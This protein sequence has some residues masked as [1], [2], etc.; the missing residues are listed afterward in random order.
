LIIQG[1]VCVVCE[2]GVKGYDGRFR[3]HLL[4]NESNYELQLSKGGPLRL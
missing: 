2:G 3:F 1:W 4:V